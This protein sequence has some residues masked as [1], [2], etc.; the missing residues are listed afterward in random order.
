MNN[1]RLLAVLL[2]AFIALS[3]KPLLAQ[4]S[5]PLKLTEAIELSIKNS[6]LLKNNKALID[7]AS[8]ALKETLNNRLPEVGFSGSYMYFPITPTISS[9]MKTGDSSGAGSG[10]VTQAMYGMASASVPLYTGG[11]LKYGVESAKY[12]EKAATLDADDN[13]EE[14]IFNTIDAFA[15]LYKAQAAM[16]LVREELEQS[17]QRVKEFSNLEKN[18]LLPRNDLL[19]AELQA[20]N[21]ELAVL[22]VENNFRLANVNMTIMLGLPRQTLLSPDSASLQ[23]NIA[24]KSIEDYEQLALQNRK[25]IEA[26]TYRKKAA[27]SNIKSVKGEYYPSIS[28]SGGYA[29][30]DVPNLLS[31]TNIVN[32]GVGVKYSL[33][34]LWKTDAKVQ[35]A[36][37]VEQQ[38]AANENM[39]RDNISLQ[40]NRMYQQYLLSNKKISVYSKAVDQAEENYRIT[41]NKYANSLATTTDLLDADVAQL[42]ARLNYTLSK[43]DAIVAYNKLQQT[44]GLLDAKQ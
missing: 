2:G 18:G 23:Q 33:S 13:R 4:E 15:N 44:A 19:K 16:A 36:K 20:S 12:L 11:R 39:L 30:V 5:R 37:A 24:L 28:L 25:D 35:R 7:E 17:R 26:L 32:V 40:I 10:K 29:A 1:K 3:C 31:A 8:A 38:I 14:V 6:S 27:Q 42:Q 43:T 22:D 41:K 34:S 21:A 9:S